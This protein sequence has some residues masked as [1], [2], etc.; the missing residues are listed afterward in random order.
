MIESTGT[1]PRVSWVFLSRLL[2]TD[3]PCSLA[4]FNRLYRV[5]KAVKLTLDSYVLSDHT[6]TP[7]MIEEAVPGRLGASAV[8]SRCRIRGPWCFPP[9]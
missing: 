9:P 5:L 3:D 6:F 4:G 1:H 2:C 7:C 8:G